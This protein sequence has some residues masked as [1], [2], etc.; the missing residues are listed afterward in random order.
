[1]LKLQAVITAKAAIIQQINVL[2]F[3]NK[4]FAVFFKS[5]PP[6]FVAANGCRDIK[7]ADVH[8]P[9]RSLFPSARR[10]AR[11]D[12]TGLGNRQADL[13]GDDVAAK[14]GQQF[15]GQHV[16]QN[17]RLQ[18]GGIAVY[19][20]EKGILCEQFGTKLD[21]GIDAFLDFHISPFGPR[22]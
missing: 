10:A 16:G 22:P 14:T 17:R 13:A 18:T 19:K 7:R 1:M 8:P 4:R 15:C 9:G 11:Q 6:C 20:H 12:Q 2:Y 21:K 5:I 3:E